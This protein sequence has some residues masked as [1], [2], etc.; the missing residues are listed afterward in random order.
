VALRL[1]EFLA[2]ARPSRA[3]GELFS[4]P[5]LIAIASPLP[6]SAVEKPARGAAMKN[7]TID[8]T[9]SA[10]GLRQWAAQ[11]ESRAKDPMCTGPEYERLMTMRTALLDLA[12]TQ[13]WLD[14]QNAPIADLA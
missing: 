4:G 12:D 5:G 11:C 7:A 1:A 8:T 13:E 9:I 14:G 6:E 3:G 2:A 10:A